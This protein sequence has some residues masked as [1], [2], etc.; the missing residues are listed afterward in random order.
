MLHFRGNASSPTI[1]YG[2]GGSAVFGSGDGFGME[3]RSLS[4]AWPND[5]LDRMPP[6]LRQPASPMSTSTNLYQRTMIII[7]Y[8]H[9]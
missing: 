2:R 3:S 8:L 9:G 4:N 1:T 6:S 7:I 5:E